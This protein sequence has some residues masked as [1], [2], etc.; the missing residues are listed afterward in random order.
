MVA[1]CSAAKRLEALRNM[2]STRLRTT[3]CVSNIRDVTPR[4]AM[5]SPCFELGLRIVLGHDFSQQCG[6]EVAATQNRDYITASRKLGFVEEIGSKRH[7]AARLGHQ[8]HLA[9]HPPHC[10]P[11]FVFFH[12]SEEHTSELQS[13]MYLVCRLLLEKKTT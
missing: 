12:R 7:R 10:F 13:P 1:P 3:D 6:L 11:D 8:A 4:A 5:R 2:N 9:H